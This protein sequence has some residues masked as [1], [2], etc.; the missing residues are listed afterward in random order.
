M[1]DKTRMYKKNQN[2]SLSLV[3]EEDGRGERVR[4]GR[5]PLL[6]QVPHFP[7]VDW[8]IESGLELRGR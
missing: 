7:T 2:P 4:E 8:G 5:S 1:P 3:E 6:R